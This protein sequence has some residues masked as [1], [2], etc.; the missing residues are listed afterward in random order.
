MA[1]VIGGLVLNNNLNWENR[2]KE[3][4]VVQSNRRFL[5]GNLYTLQAVLELGSSI[6]LRATENQG[7]FT[8]TQMDTIIVMA[9]AV[10][11]VYTLDY[12]GDINSVLFD[13]SGGSA[14]EFEPLIHR[15]AYSSTDYFTGSLRL[16]TV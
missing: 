3:S 2:F 14:Y 4:S 7:W 6:I 13:H 1:I 8:K 16:L 5:A 15:P 12:E 11:N 10:G 9:N